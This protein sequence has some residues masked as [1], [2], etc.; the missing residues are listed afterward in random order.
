MKKLAFLL[1]CLVIGMVGW[2]QSAP[3]KQETQEQRLTRAQDKKSKGG[4][5]NLTMEQKVKVAKKEDKKARKK[6]Q[7]KAKAK[8][9]KP[10][11]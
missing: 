9:P 7:P 8:K 3:S 10:K 4:K 6:K 11:M 2:A 1:F 5:K